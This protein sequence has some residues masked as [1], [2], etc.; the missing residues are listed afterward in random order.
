MAI[1]N[2]FGKEAEQE[3]VNYLLNIG[4]Q[5]LERNYFYDHAEIDI[6][7]QKENVLHIIEVKAR[8]SNY[9]GEPASFISKQKIELLGKAANHFIISKDLDLEVQF[10]II[11]IIKN[12]LT[13]TLNYI[14]NAFFPFEEM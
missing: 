1:H 7:S 14:E 2:D 9:Y 8:R 3:A 11:S 10:D 13:F 5:I 12:K 4:H 6:I